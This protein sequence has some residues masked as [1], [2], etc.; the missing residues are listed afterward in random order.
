MTDP[1]AAQYKAN[2]QDERNSAALYRAI[3][4]AETNP[5]LKGVYRRLGE[6]EERHSYFWEVK[7]RAAGRP[8]RA[9]SPR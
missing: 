6:T 9:G 1:Q 3:A 8:I 4:E 2:L 7:L 5:Q